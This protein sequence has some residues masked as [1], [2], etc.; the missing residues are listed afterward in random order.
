ME[1]DPRDDLVLERY[2][3][4]QKVLNNPIRRFLLMNPLSLWLGDLGSRLRAA[5]MDVMQWRYWR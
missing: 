2:E 3:R 1:I 4:G 5:Q